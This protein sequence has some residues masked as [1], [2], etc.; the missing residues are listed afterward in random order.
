MRGGGQNNKK[1]A[2]FLGLLYRQV[3]RFFSTVK[4]RHWFIGQ[5]WLLPKRRLL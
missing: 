2:T 1:H 3:S 4:L 5:K